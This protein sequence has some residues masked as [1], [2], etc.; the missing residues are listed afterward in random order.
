MT[1]QVMVRDS[2]ISLEGAPFARVFIARANRLLRRFGWGKPSL[3]AMID[4]PLIG[5]GG[6]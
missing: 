3:L 2:I 6:Q 4:D 1:M 5:L